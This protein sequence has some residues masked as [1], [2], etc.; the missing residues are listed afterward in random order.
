MLK[1]RKA[2][3]DLFSQM[4]DREHKKL[5]HALKRASKCPWSKCGINNDVDHVF[6]TMRMRSESNPANVYNIKIKNS[7]KRLKLECDCASHFP[8]VMNNLKD[9]KHVVS[10]AMELM[11]NLVDEMKTKC[12]A[13]DINSMLDSFKIQ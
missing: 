4:S 10:I 8:S 9:C 12:S 11:G 13:S 6:C 7:N 2:N 5:S 1:K 3:N